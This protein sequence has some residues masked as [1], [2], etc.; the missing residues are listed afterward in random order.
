MCILLS[1]QV[2]DCLFQ[3]IFEIRK[4]N[5]LT[6]GFD[7]ACSYI[8]MAFPLYRIPCHDYCLRCR[9]RPL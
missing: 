4:L 6:K 1:F 9:C 5:E 3:M 7:G 8:R 2:I